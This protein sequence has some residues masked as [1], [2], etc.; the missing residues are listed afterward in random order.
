MMNISIGSEEVFYSIQFSFMV[1]KNTPNK[2][3]IKGMYFNIINLY[4][5]YV[6]TPKLKSY[7][8]VES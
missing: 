3:N 5:L 2:M 4:V 1:F 8:T 6:T 7:L